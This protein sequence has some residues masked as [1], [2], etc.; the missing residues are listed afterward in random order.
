[1]AFDK[2]ALELKFNNPELSQDAINTLSEELQELIRTIEAKEERWF[3]LSA[4][5]EA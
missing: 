2:K 4:K 3:E 1:M 5:L